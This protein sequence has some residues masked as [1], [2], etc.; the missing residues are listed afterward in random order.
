MT[1]QLSLTDREANIVA[2]ILND[3]VESFGD[4]AKMEGNVG[5][6]VEDKIRNQLRRKR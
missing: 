1:I 5:L 2:N 6:R 3:W 4:E